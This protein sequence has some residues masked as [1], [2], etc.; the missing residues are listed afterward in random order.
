MEYAAQET[1]MLAS[2]CVNW[3]EEEA[4]ISVVI[5][6]K[7]EDGDTYNRTANAP[8]A[9]AKKTTTKSQPLST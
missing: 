2:C 6:R 8:F 1:N 4:S 7:V 9:H 3:K 5:Y